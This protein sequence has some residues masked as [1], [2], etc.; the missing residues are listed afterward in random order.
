GDPVERAQQRAAERCPVEETS[1]NQTQ[2]RQ[3]DQP[4]EVR[5][6]HVLQATRLPRDVVSAKPFDVRIRLCRNPDNRQK[7]ACCGSHTRQPH[8]NPAVHRTPPPTGM[9]ASGTRSVS[10]RIAADGSRK[11]LENFCL[12]TPPVPKSVRAKPA[13][14]AIASTLSY[15]VRI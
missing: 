7:A 4:F 6:Q 13:C 5:A 2:D 12:V 10:R 8:V 15:Y 3:S 9:C 14:Q 1:E 11:I